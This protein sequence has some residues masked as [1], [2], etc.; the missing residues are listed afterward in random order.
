MLIV[1]GVPPL[2]C[3]KQWWGVDLWINV[4]ISRNCRRYVQSYYLW[5]L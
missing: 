4:S 3:V 5:L 2:G 1:Q